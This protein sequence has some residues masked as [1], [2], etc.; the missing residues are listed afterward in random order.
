MGRKDCRKTEDRKPKR[1]AP[2]SVDFARDRGFFAALVPIVHFFLDN[3]KK[4]D[5]ISCF[6]L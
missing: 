1:I 3:A 2:P 5:L 4:Q 6:A